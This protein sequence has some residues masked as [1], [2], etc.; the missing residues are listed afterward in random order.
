MYKVRHNSDKE[1]KRQQGERG[2]DTD[3]ERGE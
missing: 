2:I 1:L 3:R